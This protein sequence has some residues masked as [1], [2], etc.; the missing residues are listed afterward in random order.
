MRQ[1]E[2]TGTADHINLDLTYSVSFEVLPVWG[3]N[4]SEKNLES[5]NA[6]NVCDLYTGAV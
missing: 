5:K 6:D 3:H 4:R 1:R 2:Q